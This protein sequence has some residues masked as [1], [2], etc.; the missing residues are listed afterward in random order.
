MKTNL[1]S[2][3]KPIDDSAKWFLVLEDENN[4]VEVK[5]KPFNPASPKA[6]E[7]MTEHYKPYARQI[8]KGLLKMVEKK[9]YTTIF[10]K[11]CVEDWKG[12]KLEDGKLLKF[13]EQN[14]IDVFLNCEQFLTVC[15]E[16]AQNSENFQTLEKTDEVIELGKS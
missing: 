5:L 10:V 4:K 3:F 8:E 14:A 16:I 6:K 2:F 7:I 9:V 1:N 12:V 13:S 15:L 11:L